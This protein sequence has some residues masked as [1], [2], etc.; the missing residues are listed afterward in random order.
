M[1]EYTQVLK[2]VDEIDNKIIEEINYEISKIEKDFNDIS[3]IM[4]DMNILIAHQGDKLETASMTVESIE[5]TISE[6]TEN[7]KIGEETE[8]NTRGLV[9][10]ILTITVGVGLGCFGFIASPVI[11]ISTT[12]I[13]IGNFFFFF[14]SNIL[15]AG[16][17]IV[18]IRTIK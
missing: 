1:S 15:G 12:L 2:D 6:T 18:A 7:L 17:G 5:V 9:F 3:E 14:F 8:N 10:N 13:G 4:N 11:G 16:L